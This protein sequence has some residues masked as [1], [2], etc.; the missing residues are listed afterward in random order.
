VDQ[1]ENQLRR[2]GE[3]PEVFSHYHPEEA[4]LKRVWLNEAKISSG[5]TGRGTS[6]KS[7]LETRPCRKG[8][9]HSVWRKRDTVI[10]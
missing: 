10:I 2:G 4:G 9:K 3:D 8:S 5:I 6:K 7:E 1:A